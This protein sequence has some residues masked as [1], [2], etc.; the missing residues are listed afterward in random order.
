[1]QRVFVGLVMFCS[2]VGAWADPPHW[3]EVRSAHFHVLTNSNERDARH[4]AG[5]LERMRSLFHVMLPGVNDEGDPPMRVFAMRDKQ[6]FD[7]L[8]PEAYLA[9]KQLELAGIFLRQPDGNTI[10]LRL[11]ARGVHPFAT[12]YHEY[13]HYMLRKADWWLPLWLNEGLAEFYQNTDIDGKTVTLGQ[14]SG[15]DID[16][17]QHQKLLP[18]TTLLMVDHSSPY[19]HDEQKG[20]IFY[21]ESWA[22]THYLMI[23]DRVHDTHLIRDYG[24]KLM[25]HEDPV[26]AAKEA[27]G[28]LGKLEQALN[29]YVSQ[30]AFQEFIMT[31]P[32]TA[33]V[34]EASYE[35]RPVAMPEVEAERAAMLIN[36]GRMREAEALLDKV[37]GEDANNVTAHYEKGML[38][39][40]QGQISEAKKWF[41]EAAVLDPSDYRAD[42]FFAMT[43]LRTGDQG[44]DEAVEADLKAAIKAAPNYAPSYDAL[45][46]FYGQRREKLDE[47]H[48]L[49]LAAVKLEPENLQYRLNTA[50]VLV[51]GKQF[52]SALS[53]L[54]MAK[55]YARTPAEQA[56]VDERIERVT[57]YKE[58]AEGE[59]HGGGEA[60]APK[61]TQ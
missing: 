26:A 14:P 47:A 19:Y 15:Y 56:Q 27:F 43:C 25:Q 45:A 31:L 18:L 38:L 59:Q 22:L 51:A 13:T 24:L 1:M 11:D 9:K 61:T 10:M 32:A 8:E 55:T 49:N 54:K 48:T 52:V 6:S 44:H 23:S 42:Y 4:V 35:A 41:G 58:S 33:L 16:Y 28:D 60:S 53:V 20:S 2:A 57:R 29:H 17:L 7:E 39:F 36:V 21:S 34:D 46:G 12:V 3:T 30:L 50:E 37:L 40:R 5:Q